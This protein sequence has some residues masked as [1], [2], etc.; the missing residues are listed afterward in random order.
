VLRGLVGDHITD[1]HSR[2]GKIATREKSLPMCK[3]NTASLAQRVWRLLV[4]LSLRPAAVSR[5]SGQ[6]TLECLIMLGTLNV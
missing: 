1:R 5:A 4:E 2:K 3:V 6:G